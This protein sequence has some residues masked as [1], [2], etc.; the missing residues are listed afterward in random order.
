MPI[1]HVSVVADTEDWS[2]DQDVP[3]TEAQIQEVFE[4]WA[5]GTYTHL[6]GAIR[7][8][9]KWAYATFVCPEHRVEEFCELF[10]WTTYFEVTGVN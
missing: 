6:E 8:E 3:Y 5:R 10:T 7:I 1:R 4:K 2:N 9:D